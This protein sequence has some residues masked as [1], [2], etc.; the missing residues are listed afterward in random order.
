[1]VGDGMKH[2]KTV[3]KISLLAF[4]FLLQALSSFSLS[5]Y[6][7]EASQSRKSNLSSSS[8][9]GHSEFEDYL[10]SRGKLPKTFR[11]L[12]KD[13]NE[14]TGSIFKSTDFSRIHSLL[15]PDS[16]SLKR[17]ESSYTHPRRLARWESFRTFLGFNESDQSLEVIS[18]DPAINSS[19]FFIVE[20]FGTDHAEV[21]RLP[22]E[23]NLCLSC[24][25]HQGPIFPR[26]PWS[27]VAEI[28][29]RDR[30]VSK[31]FGR[32]IDRKVKE[33]YIDRFKGKELPELSGGATFFDLELRSYNS[34]M[35][36][37]RVCQEACGD[38][39]QCRRSLIELALIQKIKRHV[40]A[41]EF[42]SERLQEVYRREE[43]VKNEITRR[44][45]PH[46]PAHGFE[47]VSDV[48][49]DREPLAGGHPEGEVT[50]IVVTDA[51]KAMAG[52][53]QTKSRLSPR[54]PLNLFSV[55][56]LPFSADRS[57]VSFDENPIEVL[58]EI[59]G[60]EIVKHQGFLG[61]V[62]DPKMK[63]P[64]INQFRS[65]QEFKDLNGFW[66]VGNFC[67]GLY[68]GSLF[69]IGQLGSVALVKKITESSRQDFSSLIEH[70]PP[71]REA[72]LTVVRKI[73]K[74]EP[75]L[76]HETVKQLQYSPVTSRPQALEITAVDQ[77]GIAK[78]LVQ[79]CG[80][81]HAGQDV[82]DLPLT[83][84][85]AL[86]NYENGLVIEYLKD[87]EMPPVSAPQ[88]SEKQRNHIIQQLE[89]HR[90]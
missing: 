82:L 53:A 47:Y 28:L 66:A 81:C 19:A 71:S 45:S 22:D 72:F 59:A 84:L 11:G 42:S 49:P 75:D 21:K 35:Q 43:K 62:G 8:V 56:L 36:T 31:E 63:R 30:S 74:D 78:D 12:I 50:E 25:Q 9:R 17:D 48:I 14:F 37:A 4:G 34:G 67:F 6:S 90:N 1:M 33:N 51:E 89:H 85:D 69:E 86:A 83:D 57:A 46:W 44:M 87:Q 15:I 23:G 41:T 13:G 38:D 54:P 20:R 52:L 32:E 60:I 61:N 26:A 5:A 79:Y 76:G 80:K 2:L 29:G 39:R 7:G 24:H 55:M 73:I 58:K 70:W 18:W 16:R 10:R 77:K 65:A 40:E 68:P 88:L 3:T 27:E 64:K